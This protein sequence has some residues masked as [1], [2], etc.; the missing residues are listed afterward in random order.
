MLFFVFFLLLELCRVII[1]RHGFDMLRSTLKSRQK[2]I[3]TDT[4]RAG[5]WGKAS[6]RTVLMSVRG[7]GIGMGQSGGRGRL[8]YGMHT[9]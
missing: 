7:D 2:I 9:A 5:A 6:R 3:S 4:D 1:A 8:A